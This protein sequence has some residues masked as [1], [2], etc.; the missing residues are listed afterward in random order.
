MVETETRRD[1]V[2]VTGASGFIGTMVSE[3][4]A[5]RYHVVGLDLRPPPDG[6][7]DH[8]AFIDIDLTSD[9]SVHTA[10][11]RVRAEHGARL[12]SVIHLAA[13][14]DLTGEPDPKYEQVTVRGTERLMRELKSFDVEQFVFSSTMLVHA[15]AP[16]GTRINEDSPLEARFP[17]RISKLETERR[18]R[19]EHGAIPLV[20]I[21]P[22]GVY[23]HLG[24]STFLAHQIARIYERRL[25]SHFYSGKLNT[26][27]PSLHL[28]D[29][30]DTVLRIV[31]RRKALPV[32]AK[33]L[34]GEPDTPTYAELQHT[35]GCLIHG[36]EWTTRQIAR[37]IAKSGA[38]LQ[39]AVLE[40]DSF[41]KPWMVESANDHYE[42]DLSRARQ[43]L[44]WEPRH[45]LRAEL[46]GIIDALKKDSVGWYRANKLNTAAIA[47]R[48]PAVAGHS[49]QADG[50]AS[51]SQ[52]H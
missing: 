40:E 12:A 10:L 28:D 36:E 27:Q 52:A 46:P 7:S 6:G 4:L 23:D 43:L 32:E 19:A 44:G 37:P 50:S 22:A 45:S 42:L 5:A 35:L 1:I 48:E 15:P 29:L 34:L 14:F 38:W 33:F 49:S 11:Q 21:R 20:I 47:A 41:I 16:R 24:R 51:I 39:Q 8:I 13:Y 30:V 25:L 31:E 18:L 9:K 3:A 26:G 17:Y 2:L